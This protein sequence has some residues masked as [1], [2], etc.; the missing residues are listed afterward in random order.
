MQ[1]KI[2]FYIFRSTGGA[3]GAFYMCFIWLTH[4]QAGRMLHIEEP[5]HNIK[6]YSLDKYTEWKI[7]SDSDYEFIYSN[8][9]NII[10]VVVVIIIFIYYFYLI[11]I[12]INITLTYCS[13]VR[14]CD[15]SAPFWGRLRT[16]VIVKFSN[17]HIQIK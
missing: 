5:Q 15:T 8:T 7:H 2:Y 11:S 17:Y 10:I 12:F 1:T 3:N 4:Q 6:T 14:S 9:F 13:I 16:S